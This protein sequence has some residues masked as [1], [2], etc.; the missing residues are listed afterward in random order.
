[1]WAF[2]TGIAGLFCM[3]H[4]I[5]EHTLGST[6]TLK[7]CEPRLCNKIWFHAHRTF[8]DFYFS[9]FFTSLIRPL[10]LPAPTSFLCDDLSVLSFT[11]AYGIKVHN[12][13]S[14]ETMAPWEQFRSNQSRLTKQSYLTR[15]G[16]H[17]APVNRA[18]MIKWACAAL[19][20]L[21]RHWR[22]KILLKSSF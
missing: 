17:P 19:S 7:A 14:V 6:R 4:V 5:L 8:V 18:A 15:W 13:L 22:I 21:K 10:S 16:L 9:I 2:W 3:S 12:I 20:W 11:H 1:M